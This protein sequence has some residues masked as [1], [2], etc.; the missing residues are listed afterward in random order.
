MLAVIALERDK[1]ELAL[2]ANS[3]GGT[4]ILKSTN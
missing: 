2:Q 4:S 1:N 3:N